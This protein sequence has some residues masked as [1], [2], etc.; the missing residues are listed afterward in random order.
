MGGLGHEYYKGLNGSLR[1]LGKPWGGS[2]G[3]FLFWVSYWGPVLMEATEQFL[4]DDGLGIVE[5][6][7][8]EDE[9]SKHL[10]G[11]LLWQYCRRK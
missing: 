3:Y 1:E 4:V 6:Q 8:M 2:L 7:N 10:N 9:M 11:S 5:N